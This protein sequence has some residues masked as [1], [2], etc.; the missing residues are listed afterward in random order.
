MAN[1]MAT[2]FW[3]PNT[4][5]IIA[6]D[7]VT[8]AILTAAQVAGSKMCPPPTFDKEEVCIQPIGNTDPALVVPGWVIVA[9]TVDPDTLAVTLGAPAIY[10]VTLLTN[11][12]ATH[13]VVKCQENLLPIGVVCYEDGL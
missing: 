7:C 2:K 1:S 12:T 4:Q 9:A 8:G 6:V 3:D 5:T 10:D 13:E 11:L